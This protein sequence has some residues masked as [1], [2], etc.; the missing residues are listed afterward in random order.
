MTV[1][2]V[3][4]GEFTATASDAQHRYRRQPTWTR[5]YVVEHPLTNGKVMDSDGPPEDLADLLLQVVGVV[6]AEDPR[7]NM[8]LHP[9]FARDHY[10]L[11]IQ[12]AT[13]RYLAARAALGLG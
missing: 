2:T 7:L 12:H 10:P 9:K 4:L 5:H 11:V 1:T 8:N 13:Q 6:A 3:T